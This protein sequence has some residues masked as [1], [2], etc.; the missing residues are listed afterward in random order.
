[1]DTLEK[2]ATGIQAFRPVV[3]AKDFDKSLRFY[4]DIGF[5]AKILAP[6]LAEM[7]L[8]ACSFLL[9]DHYVQQ[10]ADNF[11][12]HLFVSDVHQWW[13]HIQSL[14]LPARYGTKASSPKLASWGTEVAG[15]VDPS[16][17]LWR[18]LQVPK[19]P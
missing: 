15:M 6:G 17:V 8:G 12:I 16:G 2:L 3:P 9:Q 14:D 1:M 13:S 5:K 4:A 10:W 18:L 7:T 11:V 19:K